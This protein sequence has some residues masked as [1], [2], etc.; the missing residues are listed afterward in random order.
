[1][2]ER[3]TSSELHEALKSLPE[4]EEARE[5]TALSRTYK[6]PTFPEAF[7]FMTRVA[8]YSEKTDHHPEWTNIYNK[9]RVTLTT[10]ECMGVSAKDIALA[11]HMDEVA[12]VFL[13][14]CT[15]DQSGLVF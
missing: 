3:L 10:H 13:N 2:T 9:V 12:Y 4:W 15:V 1:M 5:G 11:L 6:F 7:S 8:F 14:P